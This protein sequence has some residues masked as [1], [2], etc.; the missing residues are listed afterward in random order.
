MRRLLRDISEDRKLGDVTTL[1]NEE[2]V[3]EISDMAADA[4][5]AGKEE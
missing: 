4:R 2:V 5:A 1:A 3:Q